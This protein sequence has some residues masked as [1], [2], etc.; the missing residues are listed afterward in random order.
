M[1]K[2][3]RDKCS[4]VSH[5][6]W[7][8]PRD[9]PDPVRLVLKADEGRLPDLLPLRHGRMALSPFTFY[10]GSALAMAV[11]LASTPATG[12]R[13]QCGGDSHLVNFRG[14]AT[15]E[16]QVILAI[17]DLDETLPAPWE[18]DLKRLA[19]SFVIAC[20]DNGLSETVAKDAV[21]NCV[22]SYRE[23]MAEFCA[24][25]VLDLWY[26]AIEA[27]TLIASIEDPGIRRRAIKRLANARES[28]TSEGLFPKLV[29]QSGGSP[30][31][32]DQLPAIFHWKDHTC[33]PRRKGQGLRRGEVSRSRMEETMEEERETAIRVALKAPRAGAIAGIVFS[34][35]LIIS[36]VLLRVSVPADPA[37]AGRWLSASGKSVTFA[38]NLLPFAG[39]AFLWFI[40][41]LRD[42]MGAQE[43]RFFATVFLGSGLLFLAMTF[44]SSAVAGGLM[45]SYGAIPEKLMDSG[46][47]TFARTISYQFANVY[48]IRMAGV[49][50][51]STCTLAIRIGIFPRWMA[52]LG[53]ALALL[54]LLSVGNL[55]WAPLIF[56]L[57]ALVISVYVLL[58]NLR[59]KAT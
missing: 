9:R 41:V 39:V 27:E 11:D 21:L 45:M 7:K 6:E 13:V 10:R 36:L 43:D 20:R 33:D 12:L 4:R 52:F 56:P 24:M 50:M 46:I 47:Y 51:I 31:I 55:Y 25:K 58:A 44:A 28:S 40:G 57:W 35:L 19:T 26:F 18:W 38:L 17:N 2:A 53:Y 42:R 32:K 59:P 34:I 5:A 54:L 14:L 8:P 49:F 37:D 29:D 15:P 16:R 22:R 3:L 48:A 23:H 30:L 1:G